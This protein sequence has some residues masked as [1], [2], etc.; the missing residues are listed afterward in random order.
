MKY[1]NKNKDRAVEAL[2]CPGCFLLFSYALF[3][4]C[5]ST[6]NGLKAAN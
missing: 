1:T 4:L 2:Y 5:P 3:Q 6:V